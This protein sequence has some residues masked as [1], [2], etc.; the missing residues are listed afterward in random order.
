MDKKFVEVE[1]SVAKKNRK[2]FA[3][4]IIYNNSIEIIS[5]DKLRIC[6]GNKILN[7]LFKVITEKNRRIDYDGPM[8]KRFITAEDFINID[9]GQKIE[10][11][12]AL[13]EVYKLMNGNKYTIQ[14][15]AYLNNNLTDSG[16]EKIESNI[17]EVVC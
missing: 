17:V 2:I 4:L 7:D 16:I 6:Y 15:S 13:D 8:I 5:L 3:N 14:Y 10:T 11:S 9:P 12:V 1:L